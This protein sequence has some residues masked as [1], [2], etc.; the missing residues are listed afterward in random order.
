MEEGR[1]EMERKEKRKEESKDIGWKEE[2]RDRR[3][4]RVYMFQCGLLTGEGRR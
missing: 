1:E 3:K 2:V 4:E